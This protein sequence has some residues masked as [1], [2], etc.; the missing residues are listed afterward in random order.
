MDARQAEAIHTFRNWEEF[1]NIKTLELETGIKLRNGPIWGSIDVECCKAIA[2]RC[3]TSQNEL[4]QGLEAK[5]SILTTRAPLLLDGDVS[6]A[7]K[8]GSTSKEQSNDTWKNAAKAVLAGQNDFLKKYIG[9]GWI[10]PDQFDFG[11]QVLSAIQMR[12]RSH[13]DSI[14]MFVSVVTFLTE[15]SKTSFADHSLFNFGEWKD[16]MIRLLDSLPN[17]TVNTAIIELINKLAMFLES[18]DS[19]THTRHAAK[20]GDTC[21]F[22]TQYCHWGN[23]ADQ[24][25]VVVYSEAVPESI[26]NAFLDKIICGATLRSTVLTTYYSAEYVIDRRTIA[27]PAF[28]HNIWLYNSAKVPQM[29]S[30]NVAAAAVQMWEFISSLADSAWPAAVCGECCLNTDSLLVKCSDKTCWMGA[31]HTACK[32]AGAKKAKWKCPSCG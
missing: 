28:L 26:F 8:H 22:N 11:S 5:T 21:A 32:P 2:D 19:L 7:S 31:I 25:R 6:T 27:S 1:P 18:Q 10:I 29:E 17:P 3:L 30:S 23:A 9:K 15:G 24:Q 20:R 12:Q 16:E 14:S 13:M 4:F